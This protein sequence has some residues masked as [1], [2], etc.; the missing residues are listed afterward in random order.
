MSGWGPALRIAR[1]SVKRDLGRAALFVALVGVPVAGAAMVDVVARTLSSP[2]RQAQRDMGS[3]DLTVFGDGDVTSFLPE[4]SRA[5]D[6]PSS[7]MVGI[8]RAAGGVTMADPTGPSLS[9]V[10]H[11]VVQGS[12]RAALVY[13]D[14]R[15]AM[16]QG[17]ATVETG[18]APTTK[19]EVML[20]QPLATRLNLRIGD[21]IHSGNGTLTITGIAGSP[22]SSSRGRRAQIPR[23]WRKRS[24]DRAFTP[25][26]AGRTATRAAAATRSGRR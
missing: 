15:D 18:R 16:Q 3:A 4:G 14:A 5:V 19:H 9:G 24:S 17:T 10:G 6:A 26:G 20:T 22:R 2:E 21:S 7:R 8:A 1:R 13:A 25:S 11:F 23:R 12:S